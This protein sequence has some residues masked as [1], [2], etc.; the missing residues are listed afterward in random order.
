MRKSILTL[1]TILLT[2]SLNYG[3]QIE[4]KVLSNEP[5]KTPRFSLNTDFIHIDMMYRTLDGY[6]LN[7]ALW[8]HFEPVEEKIGLQYLFRKSYFAFGRLGNKSFP[9]NTEIEAGGYYVINSRLQSKP[10]KIVLKKEYKGSEYNINAQGAIVETRN[11]TTTFIRIPAEHKKLFMARGG[12]YFKQHGNSTDYIDGFAGPDYVKFTS[13]GLY[14][15]VNFRDISSVFID[16]DEFGVQF[17]SIG[18]DIYLDLM[19]LPVNTFANI[20]NGDN[21]NDEIKSEVSALPI[22]FRAGYRLFQVDKKKKTGKL[23]GICGNLEAGYKP[24]I[25]FTLTAGCGFTF[26]K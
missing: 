18:R 20:E 12:F 23:L 21:V 24:F 19:I 11:E 13:V 7:A 6:S 1:L 5:P 8:G 2:A 26:I 10:T 17:N 9:G 15:G 25:G 22:G 4:Y 16:T 3:Q 14:A